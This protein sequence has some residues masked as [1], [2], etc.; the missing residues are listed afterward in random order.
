MLSRRV[1][2]DRETVLNLL[3]EVELWPAVFPHIRSAQVVRRDGREKL[4]KVSASWHGLPVNYTATLTTDSERGM[5]TI[6][7]VSAL[8]RGSVATWSVRPAPV[9]ATNATA[10]VELIVRQGVTVA[11]PVL[12]PI[13]ARQLVGGKVARELGQAMLDRIGEVARGGSLAAQR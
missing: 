8:T 12:G 9:N 5:V 1:A 3:S 6:R 11:V 4:V 7:H 2:A 13:L 10:G